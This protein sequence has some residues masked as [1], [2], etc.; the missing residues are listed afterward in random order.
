MQLHRKTLKR[1]IPLLC[2]VLL[3]T[4]TLSGCSNNLGS[5]NAQAAD[6]QSTH[7]TNT[8]L[9]NVDSTTASAASHGVERDNKFH[10]DAASASAASS[11]TSSA[12]FPV[13]SRAVTNR[14]TLLYS[15]PGDGSIVKTLAQGEQISITASS[16]ALWFQVT[17]ADSTSGYVYSEHLSLMNADNT[18][19]AQNAAD[20]YIAEKVAAL[21]SKFPEGTYW[22]DIGQQTDS[23]YS[24]TTTP[25]EHSIYGE[26]YCNVYNGVMLDC[27]H[28]YGYLCQCL[29]FASLMSDV[30]FGE[31]APIYFYYSFDDVHVGDH[32]RL[33][34]NEHSMVVVAKEGDA[35]TVAEC[36]ANYEDCLI[37]W[38][39]EF[40]RDDF[41]S[42]GG[43]MF[44][45]SRYPMWNDDGTLV[46][47]SSDEALLNYQEGVAVIEDAYYSWYG[48]GY[49][50]D[51]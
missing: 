27:F 3:L 31:Q 32:L 29:G 1:R 51:Y 44:V 50:S 42:Y 33:N 4:A 40:T 24:V 43:D 47:D 45:I 28:Q 20:E 25:C 21:R 8:S 34:I 15:T 48:Y 14:E 36:N 46:T 37:S 11:P 22:N 10:Q 35:L 39:R 38:S 19:S 9:E 13:L 7:A 2:A 5:A 23:P 17:T 26:E 6:T 41:D 49:N 30:I 18:V 16:L 12:A